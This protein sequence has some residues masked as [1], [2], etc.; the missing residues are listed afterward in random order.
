MRENLQKKACFFDQINLYFEFYSRS[1]LSRIW[2]LS[3]TIFSTSHT[4]Y[5]LRLNVNTRS[6]AL[7]EDKSKCRQSRFILGT[8]VNDC[9]FSVAQPINNGIP[10]TF[11]M[12]TNCVVQAIQCN[13]MNYHV[14]SLIPALA[15]NV[16]A[17]SNIIQR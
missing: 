12:Q 10:R 11:V 15:L 14:V 5:L 13:P 2:A 1:F 7:A 8:N 3:C 16:R 6:K 9:G 17:Y 4:L